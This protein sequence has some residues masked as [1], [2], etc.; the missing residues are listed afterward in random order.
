MITDCE[1]TEA[2]TEARTRYSGAEV[3]FYRAKSIAMRAWEEVSA[4]S[5]A[6]A[7]LES[8][9]AISA[10]RREAAARRARILADRPFVTQPVG[11]RQTPEELS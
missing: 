3:A 4:A 7:D 2:L 8:Q 9:R 5:E 6:L 10:A 11:A 1:F